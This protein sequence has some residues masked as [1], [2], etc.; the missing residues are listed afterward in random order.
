MLFPVLLLIKRQIIELSHPFLDNIGLAKQMKSGKKFMK[1]DRQ[2]SSKSLKQEEPLF[3][4]YTDLFCNFLLVVSSLMSNHK[5]VE[6]LIST[7]FIKNPLFMETL[8]KYVKYIF[9]NDLTKEIK[10][11]LGFYRHCLEIYNQRKLRNHE[12]KSIKILFNH[13]SIFFYP[14][15]GCIANKLE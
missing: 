9:E 14:K 6:R 2:D 8:E 1:K 15:I 10:R 3:V 4:T 7:I 13:L 12:S 5:H 11:V